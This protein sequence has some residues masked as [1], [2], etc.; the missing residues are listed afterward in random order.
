MR[1]ILERTH[2]FPLVKRSKNEVNPCMVSSHISETMASKPLV[3]E[4]EVT[5]L[6]RSMRLPRKRDK[7][8]LL[9]QVEWRLTRR[10]MMIK[11]ERFPPDVVALILAFV[12]NESEK[13]SIKKENKE[14]YAR[15]YARR[16]QLTV[17]REGV[18]TWNRWNGWSVVPNDRFAKMRDGARRSL[19]TLAKEM[20]DHPAFPWL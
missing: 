6:A 19:E 1:D 3:L 7:M 12:G 16:G 11:W 18:Q 15:Q 9:K 17:F 14:K 20:G 2:F 5:T 8:V 10:V 13:E 4:D